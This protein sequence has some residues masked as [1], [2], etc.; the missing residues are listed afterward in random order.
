MSLA[1]QLDT[2]TG[3]AAGTVDRHATTET[4]ES[5]APAGGAVVGVF[6]VHDEAAVGKTVARARVAAQQ[7]AALGFDG[8]KQRL[9]AY[10][11]YLARRMHELAD[12]VHRENGKPHADA[13]L[14]ITLAVDH[15]AWAAGH[16]RKALGPRRVSPGLLAANHAAYLEYQPLG[17]I[18]V[19]GPW[20]YPVFTPMGS[21]AYALAAGNAVVFKPSEHTPAVGAWL[22][23]AW[24]AAV[25]D[26]AD[27]FQ[28]VTGYGA[29]GAA[30]CRVPVDKLAFTG[31]AATGKKVMAACAETLT[32]VLME[33][34]GKDAMIV[35][36]D[37]DVAAAADAAVWGAMSNGGQT[38]IGIERVY[39]TEAVYD[40]FVEAVTTQVRSLRPGADGEAT[41]GPM[42]MASQMEVVRRHVADAEAA[43]ARVVTGGPSADAFPAGGYVPPTV[44]LDVPEDS[45]AIKEETFGPTLT[46]TRVRD[47]EEA[48]RRAN[49]TTYGLAGAIFSASKEKAMDLARRMRSGMTSINSVLTFASVPALPFGG[50]GDSGFGRIHG[51]DGLKEF[52]RAKAITRQR[53]PLP[54]N[55]M[56]FGRPANAADALARVMGMVH[57]RHR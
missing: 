28:V 10:R 54:V 22:A 50:V 24:R 38:C 5:T 12:L 57:G 29:T 6:P 16:A 1:E 33:L 53:V 35:D 36:D 15:L 42:T 31:S 48:L 40:R 20:N 49:D 19:I 45:P 23:A 9:S 8:R 27:A 41:Y 17:V 34:G 26:S 30:L 25:P 43:G 18:G 3:S 39:A 44:L 14:E 32:P 2:V 56:S 46:I 51:E 7:W 11:G 47:A 37:A 52:T 55:L 21:I 4:F 13:I